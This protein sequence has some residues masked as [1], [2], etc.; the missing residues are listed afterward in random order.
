MTLSEVGERADD[1]MTGEMHGRYGAELG[2]SK[3]GRGAM[4]RDLE[5]GK[6]DTGR[7]D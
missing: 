7:E 4:G 2:D 5:E 6:G 3:D 1:G